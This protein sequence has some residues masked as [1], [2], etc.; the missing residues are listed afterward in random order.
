MC[1]VNG[2]GRVRF[3]PKEWAGIGALMVSASVGTLTGVNWIID[4]KLTPFRTHA[5][6]AERHQSI[7]DKQRLFIT[8]RELDPES[9]EERLDIIERTISVSD[10]RL[11]TL[12]LDAGVSTPNQ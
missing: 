12:E 10:Y 2:D 1:K 9:L 11:R 8:R 3:G 4:T 5:A 7:E 6:D